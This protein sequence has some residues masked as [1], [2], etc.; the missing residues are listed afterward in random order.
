MIFKLLF[1]AFKIGIAV[2][3]FSLILLAIY[4]YAIEYFVRPFNFKPSIQLGTIVAGYRIYDNPNSANYHFRSSWINRVQPKF[5]LFVPEYQLRSDWKQPA[6]RLQKW[7]KF[8]NCCAH[9]LAFDDVRKRDFKCFTLDDWYIS[10]RDF[11][12]SNLDTSVTESL[13]IFLRSLPTGSRVIVS[14]PFVLFADRRS[15]VPFANWLLALVAKHPQLRF[16]IGIQVHLQWIDNYWFQY[17]WLFPVLADFSGQHGIRWGISEF[18]IYDRIWKRRLS[19]SG[20]V[21]DRA[22]FFSVV[23]LLVPDRLRRAV[24]LQQAYLVHRDCVRYGCTFVVEWGNFPTLW[25]SDRIDA[26]YRST[27]ALFDWQGN[28]QP[29]YWAIVRGIADGERSNSYQTHTK[30]IPNRF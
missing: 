26:D 13:D 8:Q 4:T 7:C 24:V 2:N 10:N 22:K 12:G 11:I 27:F 25:F 5:D 28:P 15:F 1:K 30:R 21:P 9:R 3:I 14:E 19:F 29:M 16:E 18:S 17:Q 6:P 23:E 20:S